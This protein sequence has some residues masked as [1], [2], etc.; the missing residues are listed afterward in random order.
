VPSSLS[1]EQRTLRASIA[2]NTRWSREDPK[3]ALAQVREG[4]R[5][6]WLD[7]VD[8][9]RVLPEDERNRRARAAERA[10]M[11]ALALKS[12]KARAKGGPK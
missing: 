7:Q 4:Y 12:S 1:P 2:A 5:K 11:Q 8:P 9:D 3:L 10:H 6:K